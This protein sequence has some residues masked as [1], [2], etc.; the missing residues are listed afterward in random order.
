MK[1][2]FIT[3]LSTLLVF[4]ACKKEKNDRP[5]PPKPAIP[6]VAEQE[7][8]APVT[9]ITINTGGIVYTQINRELGY[10][11]FITIDADQNGKNDFYLGSVLIYHGGMAH[12]YLFGSP[13]S[14]NGG[15]LLV[16]NSEE[17]EI[18]GLWAKPLDAETTIGSN[19][20]NN[21][22]WENFF[23]KGLLLDVVD[24]GNNE[25]TF[26]GQWIGKQ[27]KYLA[28]QVRINQQY[29]YGWIRI[30]HTAGEQ[31]LV[32]TGFAYNAKAGESIK[33]GQ[34]LKL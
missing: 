13:V 27:D 16:D 21:T 31:Q 33:A 30:S 34:T 26:K 7:R 22:A 24:I 32:V 6:H 9:G 8:E 18:N 20:P 29:H 10:N 23:V 25:H 28:M 19:T 17:L 15:K 3:L 2:I 5:I 12:M 1:K 14:A 11:K 4:Q